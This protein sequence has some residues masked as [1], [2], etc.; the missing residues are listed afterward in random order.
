[1]PS[2]DVALMELHLEALCRYTP[3][4]RL[5]ETREAEPVRAPRFFLGRTRSGHL[6]RLRDV[7]PAALAVVIDGHAVSV[8]FSFRDQ[9]SVAWA[10]APV[11][12]P[13]WVIRT[14]SGPQMAERP[15]AW[16]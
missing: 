2:T 11:S 3:E 12:G 15:A 9:R 4:G 14:P 13:A 7:L 1:M 10:M 16:E 6:W 8:G 5:R